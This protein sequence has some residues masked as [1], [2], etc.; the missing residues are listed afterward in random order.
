MATPAVDTQAFYRLVVTDNAKTKRVVVAQYH[1]SVFNPDLG[2][3]AGETG[4][5]TYETDMQKM[6]ILP[7]GVG[8]VLR[9]DDYLILEGRDD[10]AN[11]ASFIATH[12]NIRIPVTVRNRRTGIVTEKVLAPRD[13]TMSTD[14]AAPGTDMPTTYWV[15]MGAVLVP[16]QEEWKLGL[17]IAHNSR[18]LLGF[19]EV[20]GA[21]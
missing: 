20:A 7:K 14:F 15:Q 3:A 9:E 10:G 19:A 4:K 18:V 12:Q 1:S 16:A 21:T 11:Q 2:L 6:P 5:P 8:G 13:F 17:A